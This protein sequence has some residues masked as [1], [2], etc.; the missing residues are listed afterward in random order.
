MRKA[1]HLLLFIAFIVPRI[2]PESVRPQSG[3]LR[4]NMLLQTWTMNEGLPD[5][6]VQAIAQT[7][8]RY[9][10][11]GTPSGLARFD[12]VRFTVFNH[13]NTSAFHEDSVSALTS[14]P[15]GSLWIGTEGSGLIEYAGNQF[16]SL[17]AEQG[18][19]NGFVRSICA[20]ANGD[21]LVGTDDGLFRFAKN[22][23]QRLDGTAAF[24]RITVGAIY[25]AIDGTIWVGGS[26]L[27]YLFG[28]R[29][30]DVAFHIGS[31][32]I[33]VKTIRQGSLGT[34]LV[35]AVGG[36]VALQRNAASPTYSVVQLYRDQDTVRDIEADADGLVWA[37]TSKRSLISFRQNRL[38]PSAVR[39]QSNVRSAL[40]IYRDLNHDLW[41]GT[42]TGLT[43]LRQ[44]DAMMLTL[45]NHQPL[46]TETVFQDRFGCMW[47]AN[48]GLYKFC[49]GELSK[50]DLPGIPK[51]ASVR[52]VFVDDQKRLWLG[53]N[54]AGIYVVVD[55]R[56]TH[57]GFSEGLVNNF[58]RVIREASDR[59]IWIGT[60]GGVSRFTI[61]AHKVVGVKLLEYASVRDILQTSHDEMFIGTDQGLRCLSLESTPCRVPAEPLKHVSIWTIHKQANGDLWFGSG[62]SGLYL[63]SDSGLQHWDMR[64]GLPSERI[65]KILEDPERFLWFSSSVGVFATSEDRLASTLP[66]TKRFPLASYIPNSALGADQLVGGVQDAGAL[67]YDNHVWL[68]TLSGPIRLPRPLQGPTLDIRPTINRIEVNGEPRPITPRL[69]LL[70]GTARIALEFLAVLPPASQSIRYKYQLE[71]VDRDW[72]D[73]SGLERADY[74]YIPHGRH[75]FAVRAFDIAHPDRVTQTSMEITQE[76]YVYQRFW[77]RAVLVMFVLASSWLIHFWRVHHVQAR[78]SSILDERTRVA[79]ELHDNLIQGCT[80]VSA[81]LEAHTQVLSD[82]DKKELLLRHA[83]RQIS[84]TISHTRRAVWDLRSGSMQGELDSR[85]RAMADQFTKD[86]SLPIVLHV[87]GRSYSMQSS[88]E[89]ELV[90]VTREA[91]HN[92][93]QH[94]LAKN[95]YVKVVYGR[96]ALAID[97]VDD[98]VG[99]DSTLPM[100]YGTFHYGI[101]GM[102][103][104][105]QKIGGTLHLTSAVG[106]GTVVRLSVP[107]QR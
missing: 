62:N 57:L 104:R 1:I 20:L 71:G 56:I 89:D 66:N 35:G 22:K 42:Q 83:R 85:L 11:L 91:F 9:L 74:T 54:G 16:R 97:I 82:E 10:W 12:G 24:P 30:E 32:Q 96:Q 92:V 7:V 21:V 48:A 4:S 15:N 58:V 73:A 87:A 36:L 28:D 6:T 90:V 38:Q 53:T 33:S 26:R 80:S 29:A 101:T 45:P 18:L 69:D 43:R 63:M 98:G 79:R 94:A 50:V 5:N 41:V 68:P 102:K 75:L 55:G 93:V 47:F 84:D 67:G 77:F 51:G 99:F 103:E 100:R 49:A 44:S 88:L 61:E 64:D 23:F 25:Q 107:R 65:Y 46:S 34:I 17:G 105:M 39:N 76:P 40:C 27:V 3:P 2:N 31:S 70:P 95:C 86:F 59:S 78:Y 60:E 19:T 13:T 72:I 81:L 52:V 14:V 106:N 37:A 8:D